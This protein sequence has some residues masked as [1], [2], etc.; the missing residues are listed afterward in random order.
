MIMRVKWRRCLARLLEK[1]LRLSRRLL[2]SLGVAGEAG[3]RLEF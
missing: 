3:R 1:R 2:P